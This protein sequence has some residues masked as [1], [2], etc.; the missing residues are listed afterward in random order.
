MKRLAT[1][2]ALL[3]VLAAS[4]AAAQSMFDSSYLQNGSFYAGV[5]G[6]FTSASVA[7]F[8]AGTGGGGGGG[9][10]PPPVAY[11][12]TLQPHGLSFGFFGGYEIPWD[13]VVFRLEGDASFVAGAGQTYTFATSPLREDS[14]SVGST[15]HL[16]GI[17]GMTVGDFTPFVAVGIGFAGVTASHT[18][19]VTG[20]SQTWTQGALYAGPSV[21]VGTDIAFAD[22]MTVRLELLADFFSSRRFDWEGTGMRYSD[23]PLTIVTA[24]G[25]VSIPF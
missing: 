16:R 14:V 8:Y 21:G 5:L 17:V 2:F 12:F 20:G 1:P 25:G 7:G 23:I 13:R 24:R 6:G 22:S 4:P 19:P 3:S 10:A 11:N 15:A 18:G 9:G